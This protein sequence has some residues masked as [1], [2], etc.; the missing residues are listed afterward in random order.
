[1]RG[2]KEALV[3]ENKLWVEIESWKPVPAFPAGPGGTLS[4]C[5]CV[6]GTDGTFGEGQ[7]ESGPVAKPAAG[8][9]PRTS[10]EALAL[11]IGS[12]CTQ[13]CSP[14]TL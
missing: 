13:P 14:F 2:C 1:M 12:G 3:P 8:I 6:S 11:Y 10:F 4:G 9:N 7:S 5:T